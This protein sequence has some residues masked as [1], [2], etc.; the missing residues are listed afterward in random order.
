MTSYQIFLL[1]AIIILL[2]REYN[3][4]NLFRVNY[5]LLNDFKKD[6]FVLLHSTYLYGS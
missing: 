5:L 4:K 1:L 6:K 3:L 2:K